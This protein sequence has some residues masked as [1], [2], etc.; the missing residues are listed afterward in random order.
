[1]S[2]DLS[3]KR[4]K[5]PVCGVKYWEHALSKHIT[6]MGQREVYKSFKKYGF[7]SG[8]SNLPHESYRE[9]HLVTVK[10]LKI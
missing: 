10:K 6:Q 4:I 8:L 3:E 2:Y 5:C 7:V 1:M 9:K